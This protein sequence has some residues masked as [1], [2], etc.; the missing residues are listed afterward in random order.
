[1]KVL[2][3][4]LVLMFS[5]GTTAFSFDAPE[6]EKKI[7]IILAMDNGDDQEI[8]TAI[9][10]TLMSAE[11]VAKMLNVELIAE[12]EVNDDLFVF[13]LKSEDQKALT[14]KMY[15]EEGFELAANRILKIESGNNY[16]A[17]NVKTLAEGT[18]KFQLTDENGAEKTQTVTINRAQ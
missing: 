3:F 15:D 12:S 13:S 1:M 2:M 6:L 9:Y 8:L 17:L 18:Y 7:I 14:M 5:A 4:A 16:N 11:K 10:T